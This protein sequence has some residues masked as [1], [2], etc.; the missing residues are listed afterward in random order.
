MPQT[1]K[2]KRS[3]TAGN[4]PTTAQLD[5]GEVAI[6][7]ADGKIFFKKDDGTPVILEVGGSIAGTASKITAGATAPTDPAP[8]D[9]DLWYDTAND[10]LMVYNGTSWEA[11]GGD[12]EQSKTTTSATAPTRPPGRRASN[13][14][15]ATLSRSP[16]P[17]PCRSPPG[18]RVRRR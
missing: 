12:K 17:R 15:A 2:L 16:Q 7:T 4:V 10:T 3:A 9:G 18:A 6:N 8:V 13:A 14:P 11:I 1:I 5:L